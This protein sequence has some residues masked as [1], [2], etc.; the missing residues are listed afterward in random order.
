MYFPTPDNDWIAVRSTDIRKSV[1]KRKT[2]YKIYNK[3]SVIS[4]IRNEIETLK[5]LGFTHIQN[6]PGPIATIWYHARHCRIAVSDHRMIKEI[7]DT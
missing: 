1:T 5:L 7:A 3:R 6:M 2:C 4:S